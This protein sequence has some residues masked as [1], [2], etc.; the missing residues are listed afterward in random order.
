MSSHLIRSTR[1]LRACVVVTGFTLSACAPGPATAPPGAEAPAIARAWEP[2]AI[3][4]LQRA[5]Q[6]APS[7]GLPPETASLDELAQL[8]LRATTDA[9]AAAQLDIAADALF[10]SLAR[11]F[12]QGAVNPERA[13][14]HWLIPP[15]AAPDIAALRARVTAGE[16]ASR[17]LGGLLPQNAEY[18]ALRPELSR[19]MQEP[20]GAEDADGRSREERIILLRASMERWRWLPRDLPARRV[21]VH[22][23]QFRVAFIEDGAAARSHAAIVGERRTQTPSF[24]ADIRSVTLNPYWEPPSSILFNELLPQ[25]R[26]DPNAAARGGYE[27]LDRSGGIVPLADVNWSAR[28]FPY[29]V[30]QRPGRANSLGQIRFDLPNPHAIYLHDTPSRDLFQRAER[31]LSHGCIRVESPVSLA[32]A[33]LDGEDEQSL[34]AK[35]DSGANQVLPLASPLPVYVLYITARLDSNGAIEYADDI[36]SRDAGVIAALDA[37]DAVLVAQR[38]ESA[39]Q[40]SN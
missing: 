16:P 21:E 23:P 10:A 4:D 11:S 13:D 18:V 6:A 12:A 22:T 38:Q 17:V 1:L 33:V 19:V 8:Q 15:P 35:I 7:E 28:P 32:A 27:V 5:A 20:L 40:C 39:A 37:P 30:R 24:V 25:F 3:E 9:T 34:G 26:R 36:Y 2:A 31:A 14:P 29:R